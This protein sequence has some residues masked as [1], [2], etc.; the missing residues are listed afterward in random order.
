MRH[1]TC[2]G[3]GQ[4]FPKRLL[5]RIHKVS[6]WVSREHPNGSISRMGPVASFW[7]AECVINSGSPDAATIQAHMKG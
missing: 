1:E 4:D 7:C 2:E 6:A 5:C 3:C